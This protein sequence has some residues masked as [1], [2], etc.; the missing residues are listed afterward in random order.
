MLS[1]VCNKSVIDELM[2]LCD[3]QLPVVL[4]LAKYSAGFY[5]ELSFYFALKAF[6]LKKGKRQIIFLRTGR[7]ATKCLFKHMR[8]E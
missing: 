2:K 3:E 5:N 7:S 1:M 8:I 4:V 6:R